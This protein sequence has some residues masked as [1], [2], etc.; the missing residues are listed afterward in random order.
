MKTY[1]CHVRLGGKVTNEVQRLGVTAPEII[2]LRSIHGEDAVVRLKSL[3]V[4]DDRRSHVAERDRLSRLYGDK[5]IE[6]LFGPNH[7]KLPIELDMV[8]EKQIPKAIEEADE[9]AFAREEEFDE[10]VNAE[11]ERRMG[12]ESADNRANTAAAAG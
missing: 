10:R 8:S 1:D 3:A 12:M 5:V 6:D 4:A 2:A 11:V 9:A 7:Q